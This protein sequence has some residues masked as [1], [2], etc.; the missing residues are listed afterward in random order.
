MLQSLPFCRMPLQRRS[1]ASL[2]NSA[3]DQLVLFSWVSAAVNVKRIQVPDA[4]RAVC[5]AQPHDSL[6]PDQSH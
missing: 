4:V 5:C 3:A 1:V 2:S 6:V